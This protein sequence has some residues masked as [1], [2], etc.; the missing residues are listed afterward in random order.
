MERT[1]KNGVAIRNHA[2]LSSKPQ[3]KVNVVNERVTVTAWNRG[4]N[5]LATVCIVGLVIGKNVPLSINI[6]VMNRKAG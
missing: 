3:L 5:M 4:K 6:G 1:K 2:R